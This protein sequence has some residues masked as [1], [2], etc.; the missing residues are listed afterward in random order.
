MTQRLF[1]AIFLLVLALVPAHA[2]INVEVVPSGGAQIDARTAYPDVQMRVRATRAGVPLSLFVNDIV[3]L[4][5]NIP[6]IPRSV[7]DIGAGTH[8]VT[9]TLSRQNRQS[10]GDDVNTIFVTKGLETGSTTAIYNRNDFPSFRVLDSMGRALPRYIDFGT[11]AAGS[12]VIGKFRLWPFTAPVEGTPP[13][14]RRV[15]LES[16]E[17]RSGQID[18]VWRSSFIDR[19]NELPARVLSPIE[20]RFDLVFKPV[21]NEP[22]VDTLIV[23]YEGGMTERMVIFANRRNFKRLPRLVLL[24]PNGGEAFA[25]CQKIPITWT[26]S[27]KGFQ[28]YVD[29]STD[30]GRNWIRIDSTLDTT[31]TW[32]VPE[33]VT[34]SARIAVYQ[35]YDAAEPIW[36]RGEAAPATNVAV[37]NDGIRAAV[38]YRNGAIQEWDII[39]QQPTAKY[40]SN[41]ASPVVGLAYQGKTYNLLAAINRS[42]G[43]DAVARFVPGKTGPDVLADMPAGFEIRD[44]GVDPTG[45]KVYVFPQFGPRMPVRNATTLDSITNLAFSQAITAAVIN[46]DEL[47]I[48]QLNG[49]VERWK[50]PE[51]VFLQRFESGI[52]KTRG[53]L[54]SRVA[55]APS[56]RF[57]ALAGQTAPASFSPRDQLTYIYDLQRGD[58]IRLVQS[59]AGTE[60]ANMVFS[61]SDAYLMLG[62]RATPQL[63]VFDIEAQDILA[64]EGTAFQGLMQDMEFAPDGSRLV[65]CSSD[66]IAG[67]NTLLQNFATPERDSSDTV[68]RIAPADVPVQVLQLRPLLIGDSTVYTTTTELCNQG[69]SLWI[70]DQATLRKNRWLRF[71]STIIGDTVRP[72]ECIRVRFAALPLDTGLLTDTLDIVA[73]STMTSLPV[74]ITVADRSFTLL[75]SGTDFGDV[76]VGKSSRRRITVF[77]NDDPIPVVVN[78]I[79]PDRGL[80]S[81]FRVVNFP[82]NTIVPAGGTIEADIEFAPTELGRDTAFILIAYARSESVRKRIAVYG[83]GKGAVINTSHD[84]LPFISEIP[85]REVMLTNA[86]D[87]TVTVV[88]A[89]VSTGAPFTILTPLPLSIP[90]GDSTLLRIRYTGGAIPDTSKLVLAFDPCAVDRVVALR[91][92]TG[93]ALVK[94]P[95]VSA[96]P[97]GDAVIPVDVDITEPIPYAGIRTLEGSFSVNPRLFLARTV[98]VEGGSGEIISQDVVND[99]RVVR[100]R[101]TRRFDADGI[102][103]KVVGWAG[104]AEVDSS[105]LVVDTTAANFGSSVRTTGRNGLLRILNPDPSRRIVDRPIPRM[106]VHP[107]P[108]DDLATLTVDATSAVQAICRIVD[109]QGRLVRALPAHMYQPGTQQQTLSFAGLQPGVYTVVLVHA[110]GSVAT[111]VVVL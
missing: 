96:D 84:V 95:I 46:R 52:A 28:T 66:P 97:R 85:E 48:A 98:E 100:Y 110:E 92:Y 101:I 105:S 10:T 42:S 12:E 82:A 76:C 24:S 8:L 93:Q 13:Q 43:L 60:M 15:L 6:V 50:I 32:E 62:Y 5:G 37:S 31:L 16:I 86:S 3:I 73:C 36:L 2:Q 74:H 39:T 59:Q 23:T 77:R 51:T 91:A 71:D 45:E 14:E 108:V 80:L 67:R 30:N 53:P 11:V 89:T 54:I 78:A 69:P 41:P 106:L 99:L 109:A 21:S 111:T 72:G 25:P 35:E 57:I 29:Y 1:I 47:V 70:I 75:G 64:G 90:A 38:A 7:T 55:I 104:L 107:N 56:R 26:G 20:Y 33:T 17:T 94:M 4:E 88:S 87:I 34:Q 58:L 65:T 44:L 61:A 40:Q 79:F 49:T 19:I 63:R 18:V 9:W 27:L 22:L 83:T 102:A 103:G 81:Q 68:F